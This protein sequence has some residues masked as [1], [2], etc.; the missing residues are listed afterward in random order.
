MGLRKNKKGSVVDQPWTEV[1][2]M[3]ILVVFLIVF[4]PAVAKWCSQ[5]Q[6][7]HIQN[8]N[9]ETFDSIAEYVTQ[10]HK[11]QASSIPLALTTNNI[12]RLYSRCTE[13]SQVRG[14]DCASEPKM[15]LQSTGAE[16]IAPY[17]HQILSKEG[18]IVDFDFKEGD[19]KIATVDLGFSIEKKVDDSK[20]N[21][22]V[23][24]TLIT[25]STL[26]K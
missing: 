23:Q 22:K 16:K 14:V 6:K 20:D 15:C 24:H 10:F 18:E 12:I 8:V 5:S 2:Q 25:L 1:L 9:Y 13:A 21:S 7:A 3:T 26:K 17:C 11:G 19:D 4:I